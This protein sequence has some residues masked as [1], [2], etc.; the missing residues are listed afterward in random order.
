M[1]PGATISSSIDH[2]LDMFDLLNDKSAQEE[3]K[4]NSVY[5]DSSPDED[6]HVEQ[7]FGAAMDRAEKSICMFYNQN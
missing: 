7:A 5:L 1:Y 4:L 2:D 6:T 3:S